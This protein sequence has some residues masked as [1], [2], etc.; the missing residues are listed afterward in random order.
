MPQ[1]PYFQTQLSQF[2]WGRLERDG[3]FSN[4]FL[5][6]RFDVLDS[7]NRKA[8]FWAILERINPH[9]ISDDPLFSSGAH[10]FM[11]FKDNTNLKGYVHGALMLA[12]EEWPSDAEGGLRQKWMR[13]SN[14]RAHID[15]IRS[16]KNRPG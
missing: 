15:L 6:A 14:F 1:L 8:G 5:Q 7:D 13:I 11:Q 12:L 4:K 16:W 2:P 9:D 3:T 10:P